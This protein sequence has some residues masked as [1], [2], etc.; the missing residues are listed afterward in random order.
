MV[1]A[2]FNTRDILTQAG[3][4]LVGGSV[5][6]TFSGVSIDSR[7]IRQ[8][9]LF[10]A[11]KGERFDGNDF[12]DEA[13]SKGAAGIVTESD[14]HVNEQCTII[15]VESSLR[16]LQLLAAFNRRRHNI[17]LVAI[18]GSNG[19]TSTKEI[20]SSVLK[21]RFKVLKNEGNLNNLIGVPL[22]LLKIDSGHE[23]AVVEMGMNRKGEISVLAEMAGPDIGLI[24]NIGEAHLEGLGSM[25]NIKKAKGELI[26]ALKAEHDVVLNADDDAV[27]D[28]A[29]L[30]RGNIVTFAV[31]NNSDVRASEVDVEW[32][33]GTLF[34]LT[35]KGESIPVLLPT[36]GIH[37]LYNALAASAA[38]HVMGLGL[39]EIRDGLEEHEPYE[40]RMEILSEGGVVLINDTYN[41]N[42]PS[43]KYAVE[44]LANLST[45][46]KIAVLGD[47]LEMGEEAERIHYDMGTFI[48]V[49]DIDMVLTAGPLAKKISHGAIDGGLA[50]DASLSFSD[51]S[52]L[53]KYLR[54]EVKEGDWILIKG[55][56]GMKMEEVTADILGHLKRRGWRA[57]IEL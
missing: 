15:K 53:S 33:K 51:K 24:T 54:A 52:E 34:I 23:A 5:D 40:G 42:P 19:K 8:G 45:G 16:S 10:W 36:Y 32:G 31:N 55:S 25:E 44:T 14:G 49:N 46:R 30:A 7:K 28:L 35:V 57:D 22:T 29:K 50:Q 56:R 43:L 3:G 39:E 18:T 20:L 11:I 21:K 12:I 9:D 2:I 26:D 37:Q 1:M 6:T 27:M 17:P 48:S 38:A 41:A 13:K 4:I 47:M